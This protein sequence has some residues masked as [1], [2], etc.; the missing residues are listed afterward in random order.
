MFQRIKSFLI[1]FLSV[2]VVVFIMKIFS[3]RFN[4]TSSMPIGFYRKAHE[5]HIHRGDLVSVCLPKKIAQAGLTAHYLS[6]GRCASGAVAVLKKVIA[7]PHDTVRLT[8]QWM[9]VNGIMY[10]APK[11][12]IDSHH[13]PVKQFVKNGVYHN[14][15]SFWL[16]GVNDPKLSWDSRYY[17]GIPQV[18]I[19]G[20]YKS[21]FIL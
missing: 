2:I 16:Y 7:I 12:L 6:K 4:E 3:I 19:M 5:T 11:Q 10:H 1:I 14:I 15:Q 20:V 21:F 8:N 18:N 17:G 13:H 9:I